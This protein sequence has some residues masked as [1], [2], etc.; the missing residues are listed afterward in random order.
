MDKGPYKS[1]KKVEDGGAK[2]QKMDLLPLTEEQQEAY[3]NWDKD[4]IISVSNQIV[5]YFPRVMYFHTIIVTLCAIRS[6][7]DLC[8]AATYFA[9]LMRIIMVFG[10]YADK[11]SI[12]ITF[13]GFEIFLNFILLFATMGHKQHD[14]DSTPVISSS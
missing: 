13:G 9:M 14:A 4:R 12:Y 8:V 2:S 11:K 6:P 5:E 7:T 10:F 3:L 1:A